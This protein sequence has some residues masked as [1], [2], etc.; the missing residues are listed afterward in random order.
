[1][2]K[3]NVEEFLKDIQ[4]ASPKE[5]FRVAKECLDRFQHSF[6]PDA[7]SDFYDYFTRWEEE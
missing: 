2:R 4:Y 6:N 3:Y 7:Y 5:Q 1:M